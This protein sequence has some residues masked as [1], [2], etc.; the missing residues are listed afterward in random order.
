MSIATPRSG[1]NSALP[2]RT[3]FKH[4]RVRARIAV[5]NI[6]RT[7]L[8]RVAWSNGYVRL[9]VCATASAAM[10]AA[11]GFYHVYLDRNDLP[12]LGGFTRFEFPTIGH[13]YDARDQP[14]KEMTVESPPDHSI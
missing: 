10:L 9:L 3:W 11:A 5:R 6:R 7:R 8:R 12:D 13:I 1:R 2:A 14:L 4:M